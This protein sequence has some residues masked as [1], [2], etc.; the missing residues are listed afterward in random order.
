M[1][2]PTIALLLG[3]LVSCTAQ[4][5]IFVKIADDRTPRPDGR[6]NFVLSNATSPAIEGPHIVFRTFQAQASLWSFDLNTSSFMKLADITSPA[7]G[8][9]GN[10]VDFSPLDSNPLVSGGTVVF[11]AHDSR[12]QGR[13]QGLYSV[14]V[15]GGPIRLIANYNT[16]VPG[17]GQISYIDEGF[18]APFGAFG[19]NAGKVV[20]S[21]TLV[22][23]NLGVYTANLDGSDLR[24]IA[25]RNVQFPVGPVFDVV[26]WQNPW[27][28]RGNVALYGQTIQ[29]PSL[30]F[31]GIFTSPAAGGGV[32]TPV[33]RSTQNLP[34]N[35]NAN[36]HTRV[37]APTL[38]MDDSVIAFSADD[39]NIP[40]PRRLRGLYT[41]TRDGGAVRRIADINSTLPGIGQLVSDS[42]DSFSLNGGRIAF[43]AAGGPKEGLPSGEQGM[44]L[45]QEGAISRVITAGERPDGPGGRVLFRIGPIGPQA[46][47]GSRIVFLADY[48]LSGAGIYLATPASSTRLI[49]VQNGASYTS[50]VVSP[51]GIVTLYGEDLG[52]NELA[53]FQLDASNRIPAS[54]S[55]SR[56]LFNG[57]P[58][59]LLYTSATQSSAIVP[60]SLDGAANVEIVAQYQ[61]RVSLP[62]TVPVRPA[63]PGLFSA[64]GTGSGAG[65]IVNG[66]GSINSLDSP[67]PPG[68]IVVLFGAGF[69]QTTPPSVEGTLTPAANP[70]RLRAPVAVTIDGRPAEVL[71]Q[72]PAPGAIAG[73]YQFNVRVPVGAPSG[74][75]PVKITIAG[76]ATQDNLTVSVGVP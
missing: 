33:F 68:S 70:P 17:G 6:G 48:G 56:I 43:R 37:R 32:P 30:G 14:P 57:T 10:F 11:L 23:G 39:F 31:N 46:M 15:T 36:F 76:A 42:F 1:S 66:D 62:L 29:D 34:G 72:G 16:R 4:D 22:D 20:F 5:I 44:F 35:S 12:T 50:N 64:D 8:G 53:T 3:S 9:T 75:L 63:D 47:A 27:I 21:A 52:P 19:V 7:P 28:W 2:T 60:F 24:L 59:P 26:V 49:S 58:G 40:T 13:S 38:Q 69:G 73:L 67:A 65:A 41:I 18:R 54:L 25:D 45:W 61:D 55:G 51:G 71:Y 74:N